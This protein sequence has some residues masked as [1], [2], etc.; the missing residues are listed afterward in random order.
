MLESVK[1]NIKSISNVHVASQ[2]YKNL[3]I[4]STPRSGS[5]WLME[6]IWSQPGFKTCNEPLNIR[7]PRIRTTLGIS[8]WADLYRQDAK[9]KVLDY[10]AGIQRGG[11]AFL[12]PSPFRKHYRP[13]TSRIVYKIINGGELWIEDIAE[14]TNSE[15]IF[16]IRHPFA[17]SLSR[18][19]LPRLEVLCSDPVLS[20]FNRTVQGI[21]ENILKEGSFMEKAVLSWCLQ[22]RLALDHMSGRKATVLTYEQLVLEPE[23]ILNDLAQRF[24]LSRVDAMLKHFNT[25]SAVTVQSEKGAGQLIRDNK[26]NSIINKWKRQIDEEQAAALWPIVEAFDLQIY[27]RQTSYPLEKYQFKS[28]Y[29]RPA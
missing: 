12:N 5:T 24:H 23:Y 14:I 13:F 8:S 11:H 6:L 28:L 27:D 22:N 16:L 20:G 9:A 17:V 4:S 25:P 1:Q 10:F 19:Q 29:D 7:L 3:I 15:I 26:K 21:A 18:K 2:E